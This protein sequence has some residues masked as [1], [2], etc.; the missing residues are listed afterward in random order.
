MGRI[1]RYVAVKH[2]HDRFAAN[3]LPASEAWQEIE[4]AVAAALQTGPRVRSEPASSSTLAVRRQSATVASTLL[5][6]PGVTSTDGRVVRVSGHL[7]ALYRLFCVWMRSSGLPD[8]PA[9]LL[10]NVALVSAKP[11]DRPP[12]PRPRGTPAPH[13]S[14]RQEAPDS[15][16][17]SRQH[18][19]EA[20]D[21][22]SL[23][24][25]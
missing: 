1:R 21:S 2:A 5:G 25:R 8:K 12:P 20:D 22:G 4:K 3:L 11:R 6:I 17:L 18:E 23:R 10:L 13:A 7:P 14:G 19:G 15:P 9:T 24:R 16:A